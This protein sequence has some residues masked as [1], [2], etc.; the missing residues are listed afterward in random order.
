M[1]QEC[2]GMESDD[3]ARIYLCASQWNLLVIIIQNS[4]IWS[5][6]HNQSFS[7]VDI[8]FLIWIFEKKNADGYQKLCFIAEIG[9]ALQPNTKSRTDVTITKVNLY[10]LT[11]LKIKK[12]IIYLK[13]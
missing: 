10:H 1:F 13:S 11:L 2:T 6:L 3:L 9:A 12:S 5:F 4:Y 7:S 8:Y